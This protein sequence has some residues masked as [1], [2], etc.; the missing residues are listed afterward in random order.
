LTASLPEIDNLVLDKV[1]QWK[2]MK[3]AI[4][5]C[6]TPSN[7][8][9][10]LICGALILAGCHTMVETPPIKEGMTR[11]A[12]MKQ[13]LTFVPGFANFNGSYQQEA[14]YKGRRIGVVQ[15]LAP[16]TSES[17]TDTVMFWKPKKTRLFLR[18]SLD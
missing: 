17:P 8:R 6:S 14:I 4:A 5:L 18:Q 11:R 16:N 3:K 13:G 9:S 10:L 12:L 1:R 15:F 7:V 2:Q